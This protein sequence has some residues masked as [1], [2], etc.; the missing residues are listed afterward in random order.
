MDENGCTVSF[1]FFSH[2]YSWDS[3]K[4]K[5][6]ENYNNSIGYRQPYLEGVVFFEKECKKG[7]LLMPAEYSIFYHPFSFIYV[8]FTPPTNLRQIPPIYTVDK[9]V[10][11]EL[12]A[13]WEIDLVSSL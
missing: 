10:F 6:L 13:K 12:L 9:G 1:L 7:R 4:T 5:R 2:F 3:F 11:L 8:Y